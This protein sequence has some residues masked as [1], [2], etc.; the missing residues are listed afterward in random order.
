MKI[1]IGSDHR[2]VEKRKLIAAAIE[3]NGHEVVDLG[4][5]STK[6]V[7]YPDIAAEVAMSV[8]GG[9]SDKGVL[10]CGTGIGVSIAANKIKG[11]RAAV[12][13]D[14]ETAELSSQH[15]NANVLCLP[16]NSLDKQGIDEIIKAW[17]SADFE[18][19]RHARRVEKMHAIEAGELKNNNITY[20]ELKATDLEAIKKFYQSAFGWTFTDYGPTYTSFSNSGI[21]GG[22]EVSTDPVVSG[23]LVVL[24]H[25]D[26]KQAKE[27]VEKL[28]AEITVDIFSFPG[29]HRF[30]FK[31][32]AGNELAVWSD[33]GDDTSP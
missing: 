4:T 1:S 24:Y 25:E 20:I 12:A 8:A 32:P 3:A 31:D 26:L 2:G 10:M 5:H 14:V 22:F 23:V 6:S 13:H 7:D 9:K 30:Q 21:A 17:L 16:G 33:K 28:G 18:G 27:A 19:G 15:N 11:I 29:G